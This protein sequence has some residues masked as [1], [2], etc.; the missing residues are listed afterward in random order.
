MI[1]PTPTTATSG[2]AVSSKII[3]GFFEFGDGAY[4]L[5]RVTVL[6]QYTDEDGE[7]EVLVTEELGEVR[8]DDDTL[9]VVYHD[10]TE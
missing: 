10:Y 5:Q 7:T 3:P 6:N 9:V 2:D 4:V 1:S 8:A